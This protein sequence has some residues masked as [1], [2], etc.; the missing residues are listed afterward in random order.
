MINK[1]ADMTAVTKLI[2]ALIVIAVL[3]GATYLIG[4][5]LYGTGTK[6]A[7]QSWVERNS[8]TVLKEVFNDRENSPCVTTQETIKDADKNKIYEQLAKNMYECWDQY[9][10]GEVDFYSDLDFG[11]KDTYCR[12]CSEITVDESLKNKLRPVDIDDFEI[13][14]SNHNPPNNIQTYAEFFTKTKEAKLDF[15][16][17][18]LNLETDKKIY[19]SFVVYKS[20]INPSTII[21]P[22]AT[23]TAFA[24]GGCLLGIKI[25]GAAGSVAGGIGAV[26]GA[27]VGCG[28]GIIGGQFIRLIGY[29]DYL[30]PSITI[31]KETDT[32]IEDVCSYVY[33]NPEK[34]PFKFV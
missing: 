22:G 6:A 18:S 10:R 34:K 24:I 28:I 9:G 32:K 13:W 3:V 14:L 11:S 26:P 23:E 29:A 16:E 20:S 15:G 25:G 7:C 2:L 21:T 8:V 33:Y 17:G 12:I 31:F 27:V 1:K 19:T 4:N 30:Y 5:F